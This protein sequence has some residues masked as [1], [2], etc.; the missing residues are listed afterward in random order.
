MRLLGLRRSLNTPGLTKHEKIRLEKNIDL[1][2]KELGLKEDTP[3]A[4]RN[5][6]K[7]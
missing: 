3:P 4:T 5:P 7:Q 6:K 2:E 1:L